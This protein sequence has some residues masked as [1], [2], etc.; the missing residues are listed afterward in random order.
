MSNAAKPSFWKLNDGQPGNKFDA[1]QVLAKR[2]EARRL[3][4]PFVP[5][6]AFGF[7][8]DEA[9]NDGGP[10]SEERAADATGVA[11][12]NSGT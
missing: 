11:I 4:L 1:R 3:T 12:S 7:Q 2:R 9:R 10:L 6:C 5:I 8:I